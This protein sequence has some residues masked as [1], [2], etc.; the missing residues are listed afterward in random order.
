MYDAVDAVDQASSRPDFAILVYPGGLVDQRTQQLREHVK[1]TKAAPPMFFV[2]AFDDGVSPLNS[3]LLAAEIKKAGGMA[4][5]HV[6]APRR[7]RLW[8]APCGRPAGDRLAQALRSVDEVDG[9]RKV[10]GNAGRYRSPLSPLPGLDLV[11]AL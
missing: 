11:F 8:L 9:L 1:V 5:V 2:H 10:T 4:E 7:P 3:L 6:F